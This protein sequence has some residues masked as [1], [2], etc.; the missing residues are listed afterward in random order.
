[1]SSTPGRGSGN[2]QQNTV[3]LENQK[4]RLSALCRTLGDSGVN[5]HALTIT[6]SADYGLVRIVCDDPDK[7]KAALDEADFRSTISRVSAIQIPTSLVAWP[8]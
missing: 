4:G 6:E 1:V 3:F 8:T 2:D 5:M 7:A